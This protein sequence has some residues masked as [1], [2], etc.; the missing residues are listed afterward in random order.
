MGTYYT[1]IESPIGR[2]MLT[3]NERAVTGV[4]FSTGD[5]ARKEPDPVWQY[6]EARFEQAGLELEEYFAGQR[7]CFEV[8][9]EPRATPFQSKVLAAL[10][11]IPFGQVRSYKEIAETIGSPKAVRAVGSANGNNPLAI[12]IPCHRVV[13]SN[14]ALTGFSG[15]L[16]AKRYLLS[17]EQ[18]QQSVAGIQ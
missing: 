1:C 15:G 11:Q 9:L 8:A 5:K 16:D 10:N 4:Y 3:A 18:T 17:L 14:G 6:S 13:G 7:R 2:L 12:F